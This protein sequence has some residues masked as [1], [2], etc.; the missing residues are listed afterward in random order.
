MEQLE[1]FEIPSPCIGVC[2]VNNKGYCKGCFRS[3]DERVYW[4]Q[5]DNAVSMINKASKTV[6]QEGN[7]IAFVKESRQAIDARGFKF[8]LMLLDLQKYWKLAETRGRRD[9]MTY[10]REWFDYIKQRHNEVRRN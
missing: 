5:V 4:H 9:E 1:F 6:E 10:W 2:Q 7:N 3:R 8:T